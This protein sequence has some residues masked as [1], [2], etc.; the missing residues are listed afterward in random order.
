VVEKKA[1]EGLRGIIAQSKAS[2][3]GSA[4]TASTDEL[5]MHYSDS[6]GHRLFGGI[7]PLLWLLVLS[8]LI[9]LLVLGRRRADV[10]TVAKRKPLKPE[11]VK[12]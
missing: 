3:D 4:L 12:S 8:A 9:A 11:S 2:L 5:S 10:S 1:L 6:W 7:R